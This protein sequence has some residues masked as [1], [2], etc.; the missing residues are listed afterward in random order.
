[1]SICRRILNL[2]KRSEIDA[3][4]DAELKSHIE[5]RIDD[6]LADGMSP[7]DARRN[8]A[9]RFGSRTLMKERVTGADAVLALD[10]VWSDI[11]FASRYLAKNPGFAFTAIMVLALGMGTSTAIFAFVNAALIKPLPYKDPGRLVSIYETVP[12]CP[13]CNIS[14][15]NFADWKK[16]DLPFSALEA[17]GWASYLVHTPE[18]TEPAHGT[19]V[20]DGFFRALGVA[21]IVGRD[22]YTGEDAPG[23]PRTVLITYGAWQ[24]WFGGSAN[25][26]GQT[27]TLSDIAY[28]VI[29]VLPRDFHFAPRGEAEFWTALNDPSDCDKRR[30]CHGLFGLGRLKDGTSLQTAVAALKTESSRL[31]KLYPDSNH[32]FG[33]TAIPLKVAVVGDIR[34]VLLVLLSGAFLLLMIACTNVAGLLLVRSENRKR[35]TAL[36]GALGATPA[37]LFRQHATESLVL[38]LAG[39][40]LGLGLAYLAVKLLIKLVPEDRIG[41]MP[42]LL[43]AGLSPQVLAFAGI[44]SLVAGILFT[45]VPALRISRMNLRGDLAEGGRGSAQNVWRR[46]GSKLTVL[47][48]ATAVVLLVGAGLLGKSLYLLLHVDTGFESD[49]LATLRVAAPTSYADDN[50]L[51]VLERLIVNRIGSLP[52]VKSASIS[53]NMP[54]RSWDGG[55]SILVPGHPVNGERNDTPERDVSSGYLTTVGARLVRGRYFSEAEDDPSKPHVVVINQTLAKQYFPG[56]DPVGKQLEYEGSHTLMSIIGVVEDIKEGPLDSANRAV[57][58]VPFNQDSSHSFVVIARTSQDEQTLLPVLTAAIHQIDP[59]IAVSDAITMTDW[60]NES[61]S[62]Y[63]HRSATLLVGGFAGLALLL[64]VVGLYGVI[65]YSVS[66]RTREIGVRMALGAERSSVS[67]M[68]LRESTKLTAL[69][70]GAG[71]L[72]SLGSSMLMRKLL[73]GTQVWDMPTL[74]LVSSALALSA[75]MATYIPARRA[76]SVNPVDA[77]RAE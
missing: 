45:V 65:A 20:S 47:E 42:F 72:C 23:A 9:R 19:R 76:A 66:Q 43:T 1:M 40:G 30:G 2:F 12:S 50:R 34:P 5:M 44:I 39:S 24:K 26:V 61:G 6:N 36:R 31:E 11:R 15:Q 16:S 13:L 64:S 74:V 68:I 3:E 4:I 18:G 46:I 29:G 17:W 56:K 59:S 49:H 41:G 52:G 22:F 70:L 25:V 63:L 8:A 54:V 73:F 69:G 55:T 21:P 71:L 7:E 58:Y 62:A 60:I 10:S 38:V 33:A 48:L 37:R 75:L 32:G 14:Y 67:R 57:I 28:S 27:V 35:E 53:A 77:L 51:M